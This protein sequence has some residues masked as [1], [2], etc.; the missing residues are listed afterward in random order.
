MFVWA[1]LVCFSFV[2]VL[3][4][5]PAEITWLRSKSCAGSWCFRART[6][7]HLRPRRGSRPPSQERECWKEQCRERLCLP[8]RHL[9]LSPVRKQENWQ[10]IFSPGPG[11]CKTI[12]R[13]RFT[14]GNKLAHPGP[15]PLARTRH[16]NAVFYVWS[17]PR[18]CFVLVIAPIKWSG[19][20][21]E[22][23]PY[24][25]TSPACFL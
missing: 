25:E 20:L 14:C 5:E 4:I 16:E 1:G 9:A 24:L 10:V 11:P 21:S 6:N 13:P 15:L 23:F 12:T 18:T 17:M 19:A 3:G 22:N 7:G 2:L 8:M